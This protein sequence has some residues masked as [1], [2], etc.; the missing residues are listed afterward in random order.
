MTFAIEAGGLTWCGEMI[1]RQYRTVPARFRLRAEGRRLGTEYVARCRIVPRAVAFVS[2]DGIPARRGLNSLAIAMAQLLGPSVYAEFD[3][4]A[5]QTWLVATG[6]DGCL[7]PGSDKIYTSEDMATERETLSGVPFDQRLAIPEENLSAYLAQL[8]P[9]PLRLSPVSLAGFYR[10][11][12]LVLGGAGAVYAGVSLY[13]HHLAE[14][15]RLAALEAARRNAKPRI[16]ES[17]PAEW[18]DACLDAA[19]LPSLSNGWAMASW[20]CEGT[21]LRVNWRRAGGQISDAP[22]GSLADNGNGDIQTVAFSPRPGRHELPEQGDPVR[23]FIS[24][25]QRAGIRATVGSSRVA[26]PGQ[27][28]RQG[29]T[30]ISVQFTWPADP[31]D[32]TWDRYARLQI[33]RV[34]RTVIATDLSSHDLSYSIRV[35][36]AAADLPKGVH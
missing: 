11:A 29:V 14:L 17:G 10:R 34:A 20:A 27:D 26:A 19:A 35:A 15:T 13:H 23:S 6:K 2:L 3:L 21:A 25:L 5:S 4:G 8:Q 7:L 36:F 31:R 9:A 12:A 24:M 33:A 28:S 32:I 30:V 18:L 16:E 22:P 1:W